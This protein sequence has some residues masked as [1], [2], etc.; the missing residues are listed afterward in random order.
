MKLYLETKTVR[1]ERGDLENDNYGD[2]ALLAMET[3]LS[4]IL[5]VA[6]STFAITSPVAA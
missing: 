2:C 1:P 5:L 3:A 4:S 6:G